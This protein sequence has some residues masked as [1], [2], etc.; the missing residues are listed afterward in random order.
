MNEKQAQ[1][2]PML[3]TDNDAQRLRDQGI[4]IRELP[5]AVACCSAQIFGDPEDQ[6]GEFEWNMLRN[7]L[8]PVKLN[9]FSSNSQ[10]LNDLMSCQEPSI[11][12]RLPCA[13]DHSCEHQ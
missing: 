4:G 7:M 12:L 13:S 11:G 1:Q 9:S 5:A 2:L 3:E 8:R 6:T 10:G